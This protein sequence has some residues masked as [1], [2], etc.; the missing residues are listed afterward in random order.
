MRLSEGNPF[1]TCANPPKKYIYTVNLRPQNSGK[2]KQHKHKLFGPDLP[3]TFLTLTPG[4]PWVKK[5]L[6]ITG[7]A[8]KRTFW[9]GRPRFSAR[10]SMTRR[11]FEKLCT[12]KFAMFCY[13][14]L[15]VQSQA[16]MI[17]VVSLAS[18]DLSVR[19]HWTSAQIS[20]A[21]RPP[22][23]PKIVQELSAPSPGDDLRLKLAIR[24][25]GQTVRSDSF[26]EI[27]CDFSA[28]SIRL[29]LR[30]ILR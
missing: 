30:C 9:C 24:L 27:G 22:P 23:T 2:K 21:R 13:T 12:K 14:P 10:T 7:A 11:V 18:F 6:P 4:R 19:W 15:H 5:F 25:R 20:V 28:V 26:W 17:K 16:S 29:R 3:R 8:E 1:K